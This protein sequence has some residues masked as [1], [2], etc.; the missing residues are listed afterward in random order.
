MADS[1]GSRRIGLDGIRV[2]LSKRDRETP[3]YL[4]ID[5]AWPE[6]IVTPD[7]RGWKKQRVENQELAAYRD[8][9]E[10]TM[11]HVIY[12]LDTQKIFLAS[13]L[14]MLILG[15][16]HNSYA[17]IY[18]IMPS[19]YQFVNRGVKVTPFIWSSVKVN[20]KSACLAWN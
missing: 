3:I 1:R 4:Y 7:F 14:R 15:I 2:K 9:L 13:W 12:Q 6:N 10:K 20:R 19:S 16:I 11:G 17:L 8:S 18:T 5:T